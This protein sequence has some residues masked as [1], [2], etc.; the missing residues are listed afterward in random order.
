MKR[1]NME[2]IIITPKTKVYDLLESFPELEDEL[3]AAAPE[4]R[5]LKNPV[6]RKTIARVTTLSQAAIVGGLK[7]EELVNRLR[8]KAGQD[9]GSFTDGG[10]KYNSEKPSWFMI[11]AIDG[12]I[13][14]S[15]MLNRG[16]QPVHEVLSAAKLLAPGKILELKAPFVP[17]PLIDKSIGLE[18]DH[19]LKKVSES[20]YRLY[21]Y[22]R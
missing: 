14:I 7:V 20:E 18:Y 11:E 10:V 5:R 17:A 12:F 2:K 6:L 21:L 19:W 4:F 9:A 16:E 15:E 8:K 22:K 13:D 3:I 1:N